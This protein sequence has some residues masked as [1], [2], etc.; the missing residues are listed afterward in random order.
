MQLMELKALCDFLDNVL[1]DALKLHE[2]VKPPNSVVAKDLDARQKMIYME[3]YCAGMTAV[4]DKMTESLSSMD[5]I[6]DE[7][8]LIDALQVDKD[9]IHDDVTSKLLEISTDKRYLPT[10]HDEGWSL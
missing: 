2:V 1:V 9:R 3:G 10:K 6:G 7:L 8:N 5:V 4:V